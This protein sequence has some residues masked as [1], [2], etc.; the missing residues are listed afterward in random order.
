MQFS[1]TLHARRSVRDFTDRPVSK[2][3]LRAIVEDAQRAPSWC[4]AQGWR[5]WI[6]TGGV[7]ERIRA[8]YVRLFAADAPSDTDLPYF[9]HTNWGKAAQKNMGDFLAAARGKPLFNTQ[10]SLFNAP[11]VAYLTLT[12]PDNCWAMLDL[13]G[14]EQTLMLAAAD[15]GVGSIPAWNLIRYA[16][17][18]RSELGIPAEEKIAIGIA[19]GYAADTPANDFRSSRVPVDEILTIAG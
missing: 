2:D 9:G 17:V 4:D 1:E 10:A 11:A 14:F 3:V 12:N 18:L 6:A 5:V 7:L 19:L 13:G 15:R 16:G 8:E